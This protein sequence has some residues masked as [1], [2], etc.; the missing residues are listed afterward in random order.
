M[1]AGNIHHQKYT[2]VS[3][4][5]SHHLLRKAITLKKKKELEKEQ[6]AKELLL[7][8][9]PDLKSEIESLKLELMEKEREIEHAH[10]DRS[11]LAE[12]Y[13]KKIIDEHGN[14]LR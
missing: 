3:K 1:V 9:I 11:L 8:Q 5:R 10:V 6:K 2:L 12:L 4:G 7:E 13:D 14:I